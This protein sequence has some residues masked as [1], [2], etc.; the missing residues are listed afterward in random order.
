MLFV[1]LEPAQ[2]VK[3]IKSFEKMKKKG[4]EVLN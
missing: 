3:T 1:L 2:K 4:L